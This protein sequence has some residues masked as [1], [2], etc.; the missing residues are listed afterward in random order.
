MNLPQVYTGSLFLKFIHFLPPFNKLGGWA[1]VV[2]DPV[3]G[4]AGTERQ[5]PFPAHTVKPREM[6]ANS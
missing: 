6:A 2:L 1:F 4:L 3:A 5:S